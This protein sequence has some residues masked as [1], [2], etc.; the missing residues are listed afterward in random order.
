MTAEVSQYDSELWTGIV[1]RLKQMSIT[2]SSE[3]RVNWNI[4]SQH[5]SALRSVA[6]ILFARGDDCFNADLRTF[7]DPALFASGVSNVSIERDS[8]KLFGHEKSC[9]LLSNSASHDTA[10][11]SVLRKA[12]M[13]RIEGAYLHHYERFGT[14]S[15]DFDEAFMKCE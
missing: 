6:S 11:E 3:H 14:G 2:N 15:D 10:L 9:S 4:K 5:P 8:A 1:G 7:E 13:M 12:T